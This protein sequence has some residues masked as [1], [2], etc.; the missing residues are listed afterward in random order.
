MSRHLRR[1][2]APPLG[3]LLADERGLVAVEVVEPQAPEHPRLPHA[4]PP[5]EALL[6]PL[7]VR[8]PGNDVLHIIIIIGG[9]DD[10]TR[11]TR[12]Y[13]IHVRPNVH[14]LAHDS[15]PPPI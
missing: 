2:Q 4:V 12:S 7:L 5:A 13:D 14:P 3:A 6:L 8:P 1:G 11:V 15:S 10:T 9:G